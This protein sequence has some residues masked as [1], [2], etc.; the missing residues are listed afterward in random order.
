VELAD[1]GRQALALGDLDG[2]GLVLSEAWRVHQQLDPHCS[3]PWVDSLFREVED[4][5]IGGKLAG[6]GGG[7]F[8]GLLATDAEAAALVRTR[9]G[10]LG[11]GVRVHDWRL[12]QGA[13][14]APAQA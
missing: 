6:A 14:A 1:E 7:G 8:M 12:W 3:N 4:L 11:G 13:A 10:M 5:V 2:L 9:M